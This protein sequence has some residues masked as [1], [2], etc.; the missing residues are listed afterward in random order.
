MYSRAVDRLSFVPWIATPSL[1]A[2]L[3][4]ALYE[5]SAEIDKLDGVGDN[6]DNG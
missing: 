4:K 6:A 3:F 2:E 1:G 5:S